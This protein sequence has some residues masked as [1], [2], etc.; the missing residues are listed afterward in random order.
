MRPFSAACDHLAAP[1][2]EHASHQ[3]QERRRR[4]FPAQ[5]VLLE[6]DFRW[7]AAFVAHAPALPLAAKVKTRL[8]AEVSARR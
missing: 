4:R 3:A 8:G 5:I 7:L 6:D 1:E 2:A